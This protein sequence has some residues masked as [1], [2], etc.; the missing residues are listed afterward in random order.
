MQSDQINSGV[1]DHLP[2]CGNC[3]G[4]VWWLPDLGY[5][6]TGEEWEELGLTG[7]VESV[8]CGV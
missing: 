5:V 3:P 8:G 7:G 2:G 1:G 4:Q 6:E